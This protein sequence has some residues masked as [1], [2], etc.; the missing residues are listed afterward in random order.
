MCVNE[1]VQLKRVIDKNNDKVQFF[2]VYIRLLCNRYVIRTGPVSAI[3]SK[4]HPQVPILILENL[5]PP[6]ILIRLFFMSTP[7]SPQADDKTSFFSNLFNNLQSFILWKW[8][9]SKECRILCNFQGLQ[10]EPGISRFFHKLSGIGI[11]NFR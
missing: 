4:P 9:P 3:C 1:E 2:Y 8:S 10:T 6:V 7:M 11:R 5:S